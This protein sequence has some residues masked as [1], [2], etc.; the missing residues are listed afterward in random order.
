[1]SPL[2]WKDRISDPRPASYPTKPCATFESSTC[3]PVTE[4]PQSCKS[5]SDPQITTF[6]TSQLPQLYP[7][8]YFPST[9]KPIFNLKYIMQ[10]AHTY[11]SSRPQPSHGLLQAQA[12]TLF[13]KARQLAQDPAKYKAACPLP[14]GAGGPPTAD[15]LPSS[16]QTW[17]P[18]TALSRGGWTS[19]RNTTR[20]HERTQQR[21]APCG[22]E[23]IHVGDCW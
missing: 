22:Q 18:S 9:G 3:D 10:Q 17:M 7:L 23:R 2:S 4:Q 5:G 6:P 13:Q 11:V 12:T 14:L 20:R 21:H 1:M 8:K 16:W 19:F 15:K